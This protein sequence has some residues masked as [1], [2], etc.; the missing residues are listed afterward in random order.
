MDKKSIT[1]LS[2][3]F[4]S[5]LLAV[6]GLPARAQ[7]QSSDAPVTQ[8]AAPADPPPAPVAVE[9]VVSQPEVT[10]IQSGQFYQD[11]SRSGGKLMIIGG[12]LFGVTYL[13]TALGSA[14]VSDLCQADF[15]L[16][17]RVASWP[18]YL[19]VVGPFIQMGYLSGNGVNTGRAMLGI[20]G[21]VQAAGLAVFIAGAVLYARSGSHPQYAQR[22]QL[23]P[24][25][26]ATGTGLLALG[27]F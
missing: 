22:I 17:C 18:I 15:A 12:A 10:P 24:Y 2:S 20:D 27:R 1:S 14:I 5:G 9:P 23:V 13:A 25:S 8:P 16:G 3:V 6:Q 19:P 7:V 11:G 4:V 26:A 21:A